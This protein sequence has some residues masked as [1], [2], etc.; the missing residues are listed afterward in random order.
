[1]KGE[2]KSMHYGAS[3]LLFKRAEELRKFCTWEEDIL[4]SYLSGNKLGVRFRRQHPILFY[5]ADF[6]CHQ[7][8]LII[9]I[10]ET[11][12]NRQD[13]K[14]NDAVRQAEIEKL[15]ITVIHFTNSQVKNNIEK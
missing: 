4:W 10:D 12:H 6:Y 3:H 2:N 5:I 1:M 15:G 13:V 7:L 14:I 9:E 11:V 8:K